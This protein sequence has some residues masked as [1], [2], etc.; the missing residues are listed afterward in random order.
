VEICIQ[1]GLGLR[2]FDGKQAQVGG[3][4]AQISERGIVQLAKI[5]F[6][7]RE[8]HFRLPPPEKSPKQFTILLVV[9]QT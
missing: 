2:P 1:L 4:E 5:N 6:G 3:G 8:G 7:R 9:G